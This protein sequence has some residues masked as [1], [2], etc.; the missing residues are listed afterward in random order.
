M[1]QNLALSI[2]GLSKTYQNGKK[3]LD[4]VDFSIPV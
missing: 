3:A 2:K 4:D 1:T